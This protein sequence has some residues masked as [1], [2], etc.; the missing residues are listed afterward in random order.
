MRMRTLPSVVI[1]LLLALVVPLP[2]AANES[3]PTELLTRLQQIEAAFRQ[4]DAGALRLSF[5]TAGKL[6]VDLKELTE[7]RESYGAGQL[8]VIFGRIFDDFAT[9]AFAFRRD[10][11]RLSS[12]G[13]AFARG[14]W[15]RAS[16]REGIELTD[17][18]TF[19]LR[20]DRSDWRILEI[21]SS[22]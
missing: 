8:Q 2:A 19:T 12:Q 20:A 10:E 13:T 15:V 6:R 5:T 14:R 11:V 21:R 3:M 7:G 16:R 9:R 1:P 4:G 18:L 22:R 17:T